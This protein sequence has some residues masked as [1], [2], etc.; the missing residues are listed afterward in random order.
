MFNFPPTVCL[1]G[2]AVRRIR[3]EKRLTQLYVAKVVGVTTD[4]ISRWE[5]NRYPTVRREN[6]FKLAEALESPA[7]FLIKTELFAGE[8]AAEE[9]GVEAAVAAVL[10]ERTFQPRFFLVMG[11]IILLLGGFGFLFYRWLSPVFFAAPS[12]S[13]DFAALRILPRYAA[14]GMVIP[15][16]LRLNADDATKRYIIR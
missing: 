4:T 15:V 3:E 2:A 5:N 14:P 13:V 9:D 8:C 1:D 11:G 10:T 7:Q 16:R 6:L 12:P